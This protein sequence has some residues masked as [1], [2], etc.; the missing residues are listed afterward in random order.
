MHFNFL[1]SGIFTFFSIFL[2]YDWVLHSPFML[3][4]EQCFHLFN[5]L[6]ANQPLLAK[7]LI[8]FSSNDDDLV[9]LLQ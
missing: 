5:N 9:N 2:H 7:I 6:G 3:F 4:K 8:K 1:L